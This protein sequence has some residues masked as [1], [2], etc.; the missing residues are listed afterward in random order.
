[1]ERTYC[2]SRSFKIL[3][4][5]Y[6]LLIHLLVGKSKKNRIGNISYSLNYMSH[7]T[8]IC[9]VR[10]SFYCTYCNFC[11]K[12]FLK[13]TGLKDN[14]ENTPNNIIERKEKASDELVIV[15]KV[16]PAWMAKNEGG[17][18]PE[19]WKYFLIF[20]FSSQQNYSKIESI[21]IIYLYPKMFQ[22]Q[23]GTKVHQWRA[24]P[25]W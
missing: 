10:R 25:D 18:T 9:T 4:I 13:M 7:L 6:K 22:Q 5:F 16:W 11:L 24:Q 3:N 15:F 12:C 1:M 21:A 20:F 17:A 14:I 8:S 19:I 23:T 2:L